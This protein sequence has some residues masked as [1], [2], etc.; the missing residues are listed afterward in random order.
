MRQTVLPPDEQWTDLMQALDFAERRFADWVKE[1]MLRESRLEPLRDIYEKRRNRWT[2]A[3]HEGRPL[4]EETGLPRGRVGESPVSRS[5]RYWVF[6]EREVRRLADNGLLP[7]ARAHA[8]VAEARERQ[9]VLERRMAPDELPYVPLAAEEPGEP[10]D[11]LEAEP[12]RRA[13]PARPPQRNLLEILLDPRNIQMLLAF[14]G[15]LMVVGLIILLWVNK[16]FTPTAVAVGLGVGNATLLGLGWWVLRSTRYQLA[17]RALTLLACLVMPLN[18]W[19]YHTNGLITLDGHLWV[20]ALVIAAL[21]AASALVLRDELFV[22]IFTAGIALTGLLFLA[23]LQPSPQKFWEIASPATLLVVLGLLAIHAER[24]FP[25]Q[26]GPFGRRRFGLAFFWSGHVLLAGGLLLV[27]GAQVAGDWLYQPVFEPIYQQLKAKPS[28]IVGDLRWLALALVV[29]GTYAYIYSDLVVR[30]VG[31]YV[32]IAAGT[33]L[34]A[35]VLGLQLLHIT[36]GIDALI[37]VLAATALAVNGAQAL[38]SRDS[39][40]TRSLPVLGVVLPLAAVALGLLVYFRALSLDLKSVW[41][42]EPPAWTYVAAMALTAVACRIG[43]FQYRNSQPRLAAVYFFAT[44]A[45]TLVGATALLAALG[46]RTWQEHAPWLM[47]LPIAYLVAARLYRGGPAEQ[48]LVW[49]SHAATAVMLVSSLATA[50]EGFAL[51]RHQP[52]NLVLAL[53]FAEA[54]VFY[55]LAAVFYHEGWTIHLG[56]AMACGALWQVLSYFGVPAEVYTLTFALVGLALLIVYRFAVLE[57][58][59]AGP[60]ADAAFQSANT[61]L[62]LAFVAALLLGL[63]RLATDQVQWSLVGLFA[64]LTAI[65]LLALA[66]VAHAG[67]RRWYVVTAIGQA[68]LTF[69]SITVLSQLSP[70][71]KLEIFSVSVGL[72]LLVAGH[73][74]WYRE[75]DRQNDLASVAL[76]LGS[77]LVGVPLAI[78]TLIDRSR[79]HFIFLNELGFLAAALLLVTSGF[80]F[81]LK[82]TTLTGAALTA[83]YFLSLLIFVPWSRLNA[84]AVFITAGGGTL[85]LVGLLL[86]LYRDRLL[87]L[88]DRIRRREGVFRV[89]GWR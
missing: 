11:V 65:A 13:R 32:H 44:A 22:Y 19:Y 84:V 83:L 51:V 62:S 45:A 18:L 88:P 20:A 53:F 58:F 25:E 2:T 14:G 55:A 60:L 23:D 4:P 38:A 41:Q 50:V 24:A 42:V 40:S 35:L 12:V 37:A 10:P 6:V 36:L 8:L 29:A 72:L 49:V 28:P 87:A 46:L 54:A 17:G 5:W 61:L 9:A 76:F 34:W 81:Q 69:L 78:A 66:L 1:G 52:L 33:L 85:F 77:L 79:D 21:Y 75:Q 3:R 80:L 57:R 30:H 67:W 47:L 64:V 39:R 89:L 86:S 56:A 59:A 16:F 63:S 70:W 15:A 48:P 7:L 43:A 27:L 73:I 71:Q 26:E 68:A 31:V 74:G 82:S